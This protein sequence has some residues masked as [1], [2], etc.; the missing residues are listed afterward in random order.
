MGGRVLR[1]MAVA[2]LV[3]CALAVTPVRAQAPVVGFLGLSSPEQEVRAWTAF[4][5]GLKDLG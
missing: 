5:D 1:V 3:V 2:L 4:R